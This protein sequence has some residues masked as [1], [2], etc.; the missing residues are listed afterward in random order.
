[1]RCSPPLR[2]SPPDARNASLPSFGR[3]PCR[4]AFRA[5][6]SVSLGRNASFTMLD[7]YTVRYCGRGNRGG[8]EERASHG[9]SPSGA[10]KTLRYAQN[11]AWIKSAFARIPRVF[12][13]CNSAAAYACVRACVVR[14]WRI[15][16]HSRGTPE[17][18]RAEERNSN[19][20][21]QHHT[22]SRARAWITFSGRPLYAARWPDCKLRGCFSHGFRQSTITRYKSPR[23]RLDLKESASDSSISL[24][25][26]ARTRRNTLG[27]SVLE[28]RS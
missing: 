24:A 5:R 20:N 15:V 2:F 21:V 6:A 25:R 10:K 23:V 9:R 12:H 7:N 13:I 16:T 18:L 22:H 11:A 4:G 3:A 14:S 8:R 19:K 28:R 17:A 1:M 27:S 26:V